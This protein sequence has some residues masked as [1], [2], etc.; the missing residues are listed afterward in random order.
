MFSIDTQSKDVHSLISFLWFIIV[1]YN[2]IEDSII[3]VLVKIFNNFSHPIFIFYPM[4]LFQVLFSDLRTIFVLLFL[5]LISIVGGQK[6]ASFYACLVAH[7]VDL[8]MLLLL[9]NIHCL[10]MGSP[11]CSWGALLL[12]V[13]GYDIAC[14]YSA[15]GK[16]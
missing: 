10:P 11:W 9:A 15:Q 3:K 13:I 14:H 16:M 4:T 6:L 1:D 5:F 8:A 12:S 2:K 7:Y